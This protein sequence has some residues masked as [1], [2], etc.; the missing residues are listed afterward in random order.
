MNDILNMES[1]LPNLSNKERD[2]IQKEIFNIC[3]KISIKPTLEK[4]IKENCAI[5]QYKLAKFYIYEKKNYKQGFYWYKKAAEQG[6]TKA[7]YNIADCYAHGLGIDYNIH[8]SVSWC[9]KAAI[10]NHKEAQFQLG[11]LYEEGETGTVNMPN[12]IMWYQ[13]SSDQGFRDAQYYLGKLYEDGRLGLPNMVKAYELYRLSAEQG[14]DKA[15]LKI[16]QYYASVGN[17]DYA[18]TWYKRSADN[19]NLDAQCILGLL[20]QKLA[21]MEKENEDKSLQIDIQLS[22]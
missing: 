20:Y 7:Q 10:K 8:E 13:K 4:A 5:S 2:E 12:A 6:H 22:F 14:Y 1:I 21:D 16:G 17:V 11:R 3:N 18:I 19:N 9:I 15:Q